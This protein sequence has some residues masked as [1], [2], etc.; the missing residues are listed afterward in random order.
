[1]HK[2]V[3]QSPDGRYFRISIRNIDV[4]PKS[5][6]VY[7][8]RTAGQFYTGTGKVNELYAATKEIKTAEDVEKFKALNKDNLDILFGYFD[9]LKGL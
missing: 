6:K 8:N 2:Y 5:W 1:M 4:L 3:G 9:K 7:K